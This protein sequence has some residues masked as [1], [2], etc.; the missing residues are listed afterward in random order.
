MSPSEHPNDKSGLDAS[1]K[2]TRAKLNKRFG[3]AGLSKDKSGP[4]SSP[5]F[6]RSWYVEGHVRSGVISFVLAQ[7]YLRAIRQRYSPREGPQSLLGD[8]G[9]SSRGNQLN[10]IFITD[11]DL[12]S[13]STQKKKTEEGMVDSQPMEEEFQGAGTRDAGTEKHRGPTEPQAK[14]K[15]TPRKLA[16]ANSDKE[17][18]AR[19]LAREFSDRFSLESP[20]TSDTHRQ[21][22]SASKRGVARNWFDDL[23]PKSVD[24]FEEL[25][26]K[27]LEEFSQQKRHAKDPTKI[28]SIKR[29]QNEGLQAFMDRYKSESSHIKG[30]PP[31]L[32]ISAF[33][34]GHG[35]SKLAKK[36]NDKIPKTVGEMFERV[37]D[38]IKG[39]IA[40]SQDSED[41][42][43]CGRNI[44]S[45]RSNRSSS[46]YGKGRK[47]REAI[48][49]CKQL[50]MVQGTWKEIQWRQRDE[51][52][53]RVREQV[54]PRTK[55]NS[56]RGPDSG[57][58][59]PEKTWGRE[60][61]DEVFTIGHEC[62]D[63]YVMM[64]ATLTTNCKQLLADVLQENKEVLA[65]SGLEK[66]AIPGFVM[67]HQL[68]IYPLTEPMAHKRRPMTS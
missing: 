40:T 13:Q 53:S 43:F 45:P 29:R 26:Q 64:G 18:P 1:A 20:G 23:D 65:W 52:M 3:D 59:S 60:D 10:L 44:S 11:E 63:Q 35:H 34:H 31:V 47:N 66:I 38:L 50:E 68:K 51:Q 16:Y 49:E 17:A 48:R 33:M 4:E 41:D 58:T 25:S 61:A 36:L 46:N 37:S 24:S 7:W 28:H 39:E 67:E 9:L 21:A 12:A 2:L 14:M 22:H 19:S 56:E 27:L 42:R 54:I 15:A 32:R 57:P 8:E 30:V 55:N 5:E 6:Q 62:P